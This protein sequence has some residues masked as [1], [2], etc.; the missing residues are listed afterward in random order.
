MDTAEHSWV[1]GGSALK[2]FREPTDEPPDFVTKGEHTRRFLGLQVSH[3]PCNSKLCFQLGLG[4]ECDV[5][6]AD[7][8]PRCV[9]LVAFGDVVGNGT[10]CLA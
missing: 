6:K 9:A 2:R 10:G 4:A 3:L 5:E 8:L 7:E 1:G